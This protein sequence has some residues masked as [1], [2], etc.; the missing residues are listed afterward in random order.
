TRPYEERQRKPDDLEAQEGQRAIAVHAL[1]H[2]GTSDTGIAMLRHIL[3]EQLRRIDEGLDPI[4]VVR[5][6]EANRRIPTHAWN[7]VLS[8][9]ETALPNADAL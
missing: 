3:R 8:P 4:N 7:T 1:E 9:A 2:L 6:P 5:D